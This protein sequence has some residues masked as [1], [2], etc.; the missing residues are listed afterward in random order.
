MMK[1][2]DFKAR[3]NSLDMCGHMH[4]YAH[5]LLPLQQSLAVKMGEKEYIMTNRDIGF[6][7][8]EVYHRCYCPS[9]II[10]MNIPENMI[11]KEDLA[12][13]S[14]HVVMPIDESIASIVEL[15]KKEVRVNPDDCSLRYLYY[16]LYDKLIKT[17]EIK[18]VRYIKNHYDEKIS[19]SDLAEMENY[20]LSYFIEKFHNLTGF[21]PA[22]YL[23][24]VRINKAKELLQNSNYNLVEIAVSVGYGSHCAFTRAFK[25]TEGISPNDYRKLYKR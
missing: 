6:I 21:T 16:Y 15:I 20:N 9:E 5:L 17:G 24:V 12:I 19:V 4:E 11:Q 23:R 1:N 2:I 14:S 18:S 13:L 25:E 7:A 10:M 8:P 22:E 3:T